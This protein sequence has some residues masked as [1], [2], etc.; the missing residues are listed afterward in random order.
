MILAPKVRPHPVQA[1]EFPATPPVLNPP[2]EALAA[3]IDGGEPAPLVDIVEGNLLDLSWGVPYVLAPV[4]LEKSLF[5]D[6]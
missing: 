1:E 2:G 6:D 3:L 4:E 5:K